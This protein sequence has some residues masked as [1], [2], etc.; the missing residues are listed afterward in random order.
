MKITEREYQVSKVITFSNTKGEYGGLSNMAAGYSLFVNEIIIP[1]SESLYQACRFPL[2]PDIQ[3]LI[4][5]QKSPMDAKKISRE[6]DHLTRQDWESVKFDIMK[7]CLMVK[8]IQ[9]WK[10]FGDLLKST[11]DKLIVE[12]STKDKVWAATPAGNDKLIGCNA[13]GRLLM[14]VRQKHIINLEKPSSIKPL[15]IPAFNLFD[16]PIASVF[17]PAF[18]FAD[19][20]DNT[21]EELA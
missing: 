18:S 5:D 20:E 14:D 3:Q 16:Y 7:W 10:S 9:N 8:L 2:F 4:I 15:P 21:I 1:N 11:G 17:E 13:L 12:Y 19:F 6:N